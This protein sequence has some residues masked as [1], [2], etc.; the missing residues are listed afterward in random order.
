MTNI[1]V[2]NNGRDVL[3]RIVDDVRTRNDCADWTDCDWQKALQEEI[4]RVGERE[5]GDVNAMVAYLMTCFDGDVFTTARIGMYGFA[6][7][8]ADCV[9]AAEDLGET[10]ELFD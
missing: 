5:P 4:E 3:R 1:Y 10:C 8:I 2:I 9:Y 6:T 7:V